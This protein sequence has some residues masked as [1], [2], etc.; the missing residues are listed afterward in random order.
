MLSFWT[1][2]LAA[3]LASPAAAAPVD[4]SRPDGRAI[5]AAAIEALG[6]ASFTRMRDRSARGWTGLWRSGVARH[7]ATRIETI[8]S[9]GGARERHTF[10]KKDTHWYL[11]DAKGAHEVTFR[12]YRPLAPE[13]AELLRESRL[14]SIL[15][16][17][18]ARTSE[19]GFTAVYRGT[20]ICEKQ[21]GYLVDVAASADDPLIAVC[22]SQ[23]T[24]LPISQTRITR[25][26]VT[27]DRIETR[28]VYSRYAPAGGVEWPRHV[29][30]IVNGE[31]VSETF[32]ESVT[33]DQA[34]AAERFLLPHDLALLK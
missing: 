8:Y 31:L 10:D 30:R 21:S 23:T 13:R 33:V 9:A 7:A 28:I 29:A 11:F 15:E 22:F 18:R 4:P 14:D 19:P 3:A 1:T 16:I 32:L 20:A 12:G 2:V 5:V 26:A 25:D 6:G 17:L 27:R 34:L 24:A